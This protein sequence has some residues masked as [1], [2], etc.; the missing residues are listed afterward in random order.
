[1][2]RVVFPFG[3][4]GEE[5]DPLRS[6]Q[7][8]IDSYNTEK[9]KDDGTGI[10]CNLCRG[11]G[12]VAYDDNGSLRIRDCKCNPLRQTII[13]LQRIG[14]YERAK[15][16]RFDNYIPVTEAQKVMKQNAE[17][18]VKDS[19]ARWL[20]F[21]GQS[22]AG[23]THLCTAVFTQL[24]EKLYLDGQ[25]FLWCD[26]GRKLKLSVTEDAEA[27]REKFKKCGVLYIDDLFVG[28]ESQE[29][30]DADIRLAF[31]ILDYRYNNRL[32]T[33]ISSNMQFGDLDRLHKPIAGRIREM[34]GK[35]YLVN[36]KPDDSS[37]Y[38]LKHGFK[39]NASAADNDP[40]PV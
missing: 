24:C 34:C 35:E 5:Y 17:S 9:V 30:S 19:A 28:K 29:P 10:C 6:L 23:K 27:L 33:I 15:N 1:M 22:G 4:A 40:L 25:Y 8:K 31:E 14:I 21:F 39:S 38:R 12:T 13:R 7:N 11:D 26:D 36:I 20:S 32:R 3:A 37:N 2:E 18:F 16:A